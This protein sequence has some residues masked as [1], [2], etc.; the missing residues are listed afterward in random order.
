VRTIR[1]FGLPARPRP[2]HR[3]R[4]LLAAAAASLALAGVAGP[5]TAAGNHTQSVTARPAAQRAVTTTATASGPGPVPLSLPGLTARTT[6]FTL[7]TGDQVRLTEVAPG[8]YDATGIP[9]SGP[10]ST[11]EFQGKGGPGRLTSLQSIPSEA[12]TLIGTGQVN[13]GLFDVLWLASH[14]DTGADARIPVTIQYLRQLG[15]TALARAAATLP[16]ATVTGTS[17][18]RGQVTIQVAARRAAAFWAALTGS[19]PGHPAENT[20]VTGPGQLAGGATAVWLTGHDTPTSN[21][22]AQQAGQPQYPV[23][24]T[25]T[26]TITGSLTPVSE[27]GL[28]GPST[29][30]CVLGANLLGVAGA[31]LDQSYSAD[32]VSCVKTEPA[33]PSP[34]CTAWQASFTVPAGIYDEDALGLAQTTQDADGT[35]EEAQVE[36]DVP[37]FTV[38]GPTAIT[39]NANDMVPVTVTTPQ[40]ARPYGPDS[41]GFVRGTQDGTDWVTDVETLS[42]QADGNFWAVPTPPVERAT[43]GVYTFFT[44]MTMGA[45]PI[46]AQVTAPQHL[47]LHPLYQC[48]ARNDGDCGAVELHFSGSH[49]LQLVNAGEGTPAEFSKIDARGKL[50][51]IFPY[52]GPP[53][54]ILWPGYRCFPGGELCD[55]QF[56]AAKQA[57]AA[58]VLFAN[59]GPPGSAFF[60]AAGDPTLP[61][62]VIDTAEAATLAGLAAKGPVTVTVTDHGTSPYAYQLAFYQEGGIAASQH[63]TLTNQQLVEVTNAYHAADGVTGPQSAQVGAYQHA[64]DQFFS[65]GDWMDV[66][67]PPLSVRTYYGPLSPAVAW[68]TGFDIFGGTGGVPYAGTWVT[69]FGRPGQQAMAWHTAPAAPGAFTLDPAVDQAQPGYFLAL[70][71]ASR[72]DNTFY[73]DFWLT[74]GANPLSDGDPDT[75]VGFTP[76]QIHLYNQAGQEMPSSTDPFG[77]AYYP[78]LPAVQQHYK[79]VLGYQL[80]DYGTTATTDTTWDFTSAAPAS[81]DYGPNGYV[82]LGT[83]LNGSTEPCNAPP[84]VFLRYNAYLALDNTLAAS[85][86][87]LLRVTG[88]H[89]DPAAPPVT[90]LRVWLST[91]GGATWQQT[92]VTGGQGGTWTV[93]YILPQLSQTNGYLSIKATAADAT[94]NDVTQTIVDAVKLAAATSGQA[95]PNRK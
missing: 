4:L 41:L 48:V 90:S 1:R 66:N 47:V 95:V 88:Y 12:G 58:G 32:S 19:P 11:I 85:G 75:F 62:A 20:A 71:A 14:G 46:T 37:Q 6:T 33:K 64:P 91:N 17:A 27:C 78:G 94:G 69:V 73:P 93:P 3:L 42:D 72:Q 31:G 30:L 65:S 59:D 38:T 68:Q 87:H 28:G 84:L 26:R 45:F 74:S 23:T 21:P 39:V 40:P 44:A 77:D 67:G 60:P 13:R 61:F 50:V 2:A 22:A 79:L 70:A 92:H 52:T 18:A 15:A 76:G 55:G 36:L 81:G 34:L 16:G 10:A 7:I 63:H 43:V 29:L 35:M 83:I 53:T 57:G 9:G 54:S 80:T 25:Y 82:C 86:F 49:T 8:S 51:L 5:A 89:Q 24:V 56:V